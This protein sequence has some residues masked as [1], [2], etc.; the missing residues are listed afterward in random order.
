MFCLITDVL[1]LIIVLGA[2]LNIFKPGA[3]LAPLGK[4]FYRLKF[5]M[6]DIAIRKIFKL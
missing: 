6:A 1:L 2:F 3:L 4:I 5:K